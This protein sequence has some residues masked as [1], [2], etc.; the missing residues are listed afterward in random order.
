MTVAN[1]ANTYLPGTIQ[2]PSSLL[3]TAITKDIIARIT[4]EVDPITASNTYIPGQAV[5]LT[6]PFQYGMQQ[7]NEKT[8][9]ILN[10]DGLNFYVDMNSVSFDPFV[11]PMNATQPAS[12][13]PSG[14]NNLEYSN[15]TNQIAFQSL[16][17]IGN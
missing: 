12:L 5:L 7:A 3:I 8:V 16:N 15:G 14:S 6:I 2:I 9:K 10:V 11:V 1:N 4:V 13:S 17:N